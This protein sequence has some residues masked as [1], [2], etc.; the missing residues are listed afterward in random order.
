M[1][2]LNKFYPPHC[3]VLGSA[4][5]RGATHLGPPTPYLLHLPSP[6]GVIGCGGG[7][8]TLFLFGTGGIPS[9]LGILEGARAGAFLFT[10]L[11]LL[12]L[13]LGVSVVVVD[14]EPASLCF[15]VC[16]VHC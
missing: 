6:W 11:R 15:F 7:E 4:L 14:R 8:E 1:E 9:T 12:H 2:P 13:A 10:A 16:V 3:D 5:G